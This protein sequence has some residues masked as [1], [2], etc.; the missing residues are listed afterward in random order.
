MTFLKKLGEILVK[1][2]E[3][4]TGIG[5]LLQGSFP[6]AAGT[7]GVIEN[8][9]NQIANI[10][11]TVESVGQALQQPGPQ[12]LAAAAP[13]ISQVIMKSSLLANRKIADPVLFQKAVT[14]IGG[15]MAD[16][17]NSLKDDIDTTSKT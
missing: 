9:F 7:I 8:E 2:L 10:V 11:V 13:L 14:E 3:I 12:K 6:S 5:P 1:G 15:G 4:A 16:L 17:L